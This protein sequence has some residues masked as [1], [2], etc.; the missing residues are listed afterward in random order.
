MTGAAAPHETQV[1]TYALFSMLEK[2]VTDKLTVFSQNMNRDFTTVT[3]DMYGK[4]NYLDKVIGKMPQT[5]NQP[6]AAEHN[7]QPPYQERG[8]PHKESAAT[9]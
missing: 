1:S 9:S 8:L 4:L 6:I 5:A 7:Y 2:L 3:N